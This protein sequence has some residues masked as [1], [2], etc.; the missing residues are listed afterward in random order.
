MPP[1][2]N[3]LIQ[4]RNRKQGQEDPDPD[5]SVRDRGIQAVLIRENGGG[6]HRR[7]AG[8]QH[9]DGEHGPVDTG[10]MPASSTIRGAATSSQRG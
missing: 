2:S 3:Q 1:P 10:A 4:Q 7:H 5:S 6:N 9:R 8:L